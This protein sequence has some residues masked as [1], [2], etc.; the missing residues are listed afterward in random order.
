[1]LLILTLTMRD[2]FNYRNTNSIIILI[3]LKFERINMSGKNRLDKIFVLL[4][5]RTISTAALL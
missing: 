4:T 2:H 3:H 1:M 5:T